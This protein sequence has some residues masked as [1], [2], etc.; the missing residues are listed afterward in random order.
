[1]FLLIWHNNLGCPGPSGVTQ[2]HEL[3]WG[4]S[5]DQAGQKALSGHYVGA[6]FEERYH[7]GHI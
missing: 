2:T 3:D 4:N 6:Y 7:A 1:M 5:T